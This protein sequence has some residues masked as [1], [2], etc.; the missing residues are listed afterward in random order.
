LQLNNYQIAIEEMGYK[1]AEK[2]LI[3][4]G[5]SVSVLPV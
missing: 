3:Y 5:D 1:V 2:V 4:I